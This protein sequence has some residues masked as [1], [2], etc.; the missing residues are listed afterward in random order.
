[1]AQE[2]LQLSRP[3][4]SVLA[5]VD[6]Q[7]ELS[8]SDIA[9]ATKLAPSEV[10]QIVARLEEA[11]LVETGQRGL[12]LTRQGMRVRQDF[13]ERW[14][15]PLRLEHESYENVSAELD[16]ELAKLDEP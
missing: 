4:A 1:M 7:R 9:V 11:E 15:R 12:R 16:A 13:E 14:F 5:T 8:L 10:Q 2:S 6:P 3:E